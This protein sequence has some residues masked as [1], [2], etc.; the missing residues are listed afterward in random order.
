MTQEAHDWEE[1]Y[2][3]IMGRPPRLLFLDALAYF[4]GDDALK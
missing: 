1:Y 3:A 4:P 2:R